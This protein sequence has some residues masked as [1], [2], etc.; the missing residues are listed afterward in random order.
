MATSSLGRA[1][2]E[3]PSHQNLPTFLL[4][5]EG[6]VV[7]RVD[8]SVDAPQKL[9]REEVLVRVDDLH[10]LLLGPLL[11]QVGDLASAACHA[12]LDG[13]QVGEAQEVR[14]HAPH[15]LAWTPAE[16]RWSSPPRHSTPVLLLPTTFP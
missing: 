8:T 11:R 4:Y 7:A 9:V 2:P 10:Q 12:M 16:R 13:R 14:R 5:L 3:C 15:Q 1:E 6:G